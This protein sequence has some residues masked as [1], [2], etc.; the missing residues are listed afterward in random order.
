M[1]CDICREKNQWP[2]VLA[3]LTRIVTSFSVEICDIRIAAHK[4]MH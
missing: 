2:L 4:A 1:C 3:G